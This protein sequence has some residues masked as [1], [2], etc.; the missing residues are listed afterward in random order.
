MIGFLHVCHHEKE[1]YHFTFD[2]HDDSNKALF[3][4]NVTVCVCSLFRFIFL[5]GK[6]SMSLV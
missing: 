6:Y 3:V 2:A 5:L 1:G 4:Y